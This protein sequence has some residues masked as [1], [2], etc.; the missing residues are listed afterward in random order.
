MNQKEIYIFVGPPGS[1]KTLYS[2]SITDLFDALHIA[3][4]DI[5]VKTNEKN[6]LKILKN[7]LIV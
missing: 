1:N 3:W 5:K 7:S 6:K 4:R 2:K